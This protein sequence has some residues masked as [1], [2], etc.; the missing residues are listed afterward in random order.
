MTENASTKEDASMY[1]DKLDHMAGF[2]SAFASTL[3]ADIAFVGPEAS[4]KPVAELAQLGW[5]GNE[6][7]TPA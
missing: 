5:T 7:L 1:S 3:A 6:D 2:T 4:R